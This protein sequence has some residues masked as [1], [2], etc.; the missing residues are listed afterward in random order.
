M[1]IEPPARYPKNS[2]NPV[3]AGAKSGALEVIKPDIDP[4]LASLIVAWPS[5]P[6]AIRAGV[7]AMVKAALPNE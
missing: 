2:T 1:G 5:L 4:A 3:P 7:V 6:E